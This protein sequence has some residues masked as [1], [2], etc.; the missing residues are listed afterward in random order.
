M[1]EK[2]HIY[3][4]YAATGDQ[5]SELLHRLK[6]L[7]KSY[8]TTIWDDD[9]ILE[10][11]VWKPANASRLV[12]TDLF[13]LLLSKAFMYSE[14]VKQ[15]EFK[16]VIDRYKEGKSKVV[17]I[18][19]DDCPWD[20]NF[21][22][23]D[24]NFSFKELGV[25]PENQMPIKN[26][27]SQKEAYDNVMSELNQVIA[28]FAMPVEDS[29]STQDFKEPTAISDDQLSIDFKGKGE[30]ERLVEKKSKKKEEKAAAQKAHKT[31]EIEEK[32]E[33]KRRLEEEKKLQA[34]REAKRLAEEELRLQA[35]RQRRLEEEERQFEED[36][37]EYALT[38]NRN[39]VE[40]PPREN[41]I[42]RKT[43]FA[44]AL[45]SAI[46]LAAF[47]FFPTAKNDSKGEIPA[48]R[49]DTIEVKGPISPE[50]T[51]PDFPAKEETLSNLA[52]GDAY[53]EGVV[54]EISGDNKIGKIVHIDDYG[55]MT[56][57]EAM[58]IG[59]QLGEGWRLPTLDE[60]KRMYKTIGQGADNKGEF[61]DGLYWSATP[62]DDYQ[63]RLL[64]FR[65]G[66]ASY[67][68][69]SG[70]THRKFLVRPIKDFARE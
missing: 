32:A 37:S 19:L 27:N 66:N 69:N 6:S 41:S 26:W 61:A 28:S 22:S 40:E 29:E 9:P 17:P 14:F 58:N 10:N 59:E 21:E 67:H 45:V 70:G 46:V 47:F 43:I 65:D 50:K 53:E 68:Y 38:E 31:K 54:F 51:E 36:Q 33:A 62:F 55:P 42:S 30:M 48:V 35:E 18:I 7:A 24:Y 49:M 13:L 39:D 12:K 20:I 60:L 57:K 23:D 1:A 5:A 15:L 8:D 25:L 16:N 4:I 3:V 44:G 52:V 2:K 34:E 11:Q 56:W 64:R 63:A